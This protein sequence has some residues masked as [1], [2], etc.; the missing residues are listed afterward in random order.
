MENR[1]DNT[2]EMLSQ[3]NL[4]HQEDEALADYSPHKNNP[5]QAI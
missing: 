4:F 1:A 5:L 3:L 2:F